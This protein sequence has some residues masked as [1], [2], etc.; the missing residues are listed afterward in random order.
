MARRR[1]GAADAEPVAQGEA[2]AAAADDPE[3][4]DSPDPQAAAAASPGHGRAAGWLRIF[5]ENRALW[6]TA[7]VATACLVAGL[8]VGRFVLSPADAAA[9][10]AAP[11]AG[12]ITVPVA[13]GTLTN[14]V[15]MRGQVG[16]ADSTEVKIAAPEGAELTGADGRSRI[17]VTTR[18]FDRGSSSLFSG[19][20]YSRRFAF[21]PPVLGL[22][23]PKTRV[24]LGVIPGNSPGMCLRLATTSRDRRPG[25]GVAR[26]TPRGDGPAGSRPRPRPRGG[27]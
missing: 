27:R 16:Y 9:R 14:D 12:Y 20:V 22:W 5:R 23:L 19:C 11:E 7:A 25:T 15:T 3:S 18:A 8:V 6:V 1:P 2:L 4:P 10:T 26:L 24:P 13:F 21:Q 17:A